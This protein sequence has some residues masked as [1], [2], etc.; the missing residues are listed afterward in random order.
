LENVDF[1]RDAFVVII[2]IEHIASNI[3]EELQLIRFFSARSDGLCEFVLDEE[4][5]LRP[6]T[7][8]KAG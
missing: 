5:G 2:N 3:K 4:R 8:Q 7:R 1:P 6:L